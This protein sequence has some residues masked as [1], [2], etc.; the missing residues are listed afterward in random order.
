MMDYGGTAFA[1]SRNLGIDKETAQSYIDRYF[2]GFHGLADWA[3]TQKQFG[4]KFG[5]VLTLLGHKRHLT[6]IRDENIKIRSYYE[7]LCLNSPV[8][9]SAADC[10]MRAQIQ[11]D[12]DPILNSIGASMR[13]QIHDELVLVAPK[14]FKLIAMER[15]KYLMEHCLP[16][17]LVVPLVSE[18]DFG[19]TYAEA[20]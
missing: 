7:R 10:A 18:V 8:Q 5:Y 16:H 12:K 14:R 19:A 6:G 2:E 17:E 11:V 9:G 13:I 15:L 3:V 1:V 20:K 4:R